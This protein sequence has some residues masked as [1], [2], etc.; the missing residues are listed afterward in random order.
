MQ[1]RCVGVRMKHVFLWPG[2]LLCQFGPQITN[3]TKS[4]KLPD[5]S[6]LLT[7]QLGLQINLRIS[8][9]Y[10]SKF[11]QLSPATTASIHFL[12]FQ[13]VPFRLFYNFAASKRAA[14]LVF[15]PTRYVQNEV[16]WL[17]FVV[18]KNST[19]VVN[20]GEILESCTVG[21][22]ERGLA[23]HPWS[24]KTGFRS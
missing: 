11:P 17:V 4:H 12:V 20:L 19:Q 3:A 21:V 18:L 16:A 23:C 1:D 24:T 13:H 2:F 14:P 9:Y 15:T 5:I 10:Y 7:P 22:L 6:D 8:D